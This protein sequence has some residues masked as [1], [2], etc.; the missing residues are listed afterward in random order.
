MGIAQTH[1]LQAEGG[2]RLVEA[3]RVRRHLRNALCQLGGP[4]QQ[5]AGRHHLVHHPDP[6]SLRG[7]EVIATD[8]DPPAGSEVERAY[9][10]EALR[11]YQPRVVLGSFVPFDSGVDG[12]VLAEPCVL[13]YVRV[14]ARLGGQFGA[15][16]LWDGAAWRASQ[17]NETTRWMVCRH[18][19]WMGQ[20]QP[21]LQHGEAWRLDRKAGS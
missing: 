11:R 18:D 17:L 10:V 8:V 20:G 9:A 16:A 21:I 14:D 13:H 1:R 6:E 12:Q 19:V 5:P 7:V 2:D 4:L 15:P 3:N